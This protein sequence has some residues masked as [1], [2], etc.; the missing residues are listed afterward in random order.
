MAAQLLV[1]PD[2]SGGERL[3]AELDRERLP[4]TAA[5][6]R[7][8]TS[9]S[10]WRLIIASPLVDTEGSLPVYERIQAAL[11]RLPDVRIPLSEIFAVG[12]QD[13]IVRILGQATVSAHEAFN[14]TITFP[15]YSPYSPYL[16]EDTTSVGVYVYRAG[17]DS[18][19]SREHAA[20]Q[21]QNA[22]QDRAT[23][24]E[25]THVERR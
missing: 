12:E 10:G 11:Q 13:P 7:Y 23:A 14:T 15:S 8:P 5:F 1:G 21:A 16:P 19:T 4:I 6:W 17:S 9:D 20:V 25:S 22:A 2:L 24:T 18:G 3:L